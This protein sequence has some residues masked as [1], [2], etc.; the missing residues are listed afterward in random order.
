[1]L[2]SKI[3]TIILNIRAFN[4]IYKHHGVT[5]KDTTLL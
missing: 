3:Q 1:M 5:F 4:K 2:R